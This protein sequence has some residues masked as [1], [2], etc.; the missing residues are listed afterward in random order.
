MGLGLEED[1]ASSMGMLFSNL[2]WPSNPKPPEA[3]VRNRN[4]TEHPKA[5]KPSTLKAKP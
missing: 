1:E 3:L 5:P 2:G 4:T